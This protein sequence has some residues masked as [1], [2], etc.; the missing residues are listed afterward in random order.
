VRLTEDSLD[1]E[2]LI[3]DSC[4][5]RSGALVVFGGTVRNHHEGQ[6]VTRLRYS[7]YA[8]LGDK[9]IQEIEAETVAKFRVHH[10]RVVHRTGDLGIGEV[11]IYAIV[12]ASHRREAFAAAQYA[13]DA[14]KHR[15]PVWKEEFYADGSSA[16]VQGCCIAHDEKK[17]QVHFPE[18]ATNGE[19]QRKMNLALFS[20]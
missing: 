9:L 17:G 20:T 13:V 15:V 19:A 12:R 3:A 4:D 10:C 6:A 1:L 16:F 5:P 11:A 18:D 8:P 14:V 2:A 7:A